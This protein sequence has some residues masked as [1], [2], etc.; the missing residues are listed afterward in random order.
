MK[1][2]SGRYLNTIVSIYDNTI[3]VAEVLI[4][5]LRGNIISIEFNL[6]NQMMKLTGIL[7]MEGHNVQI[8]VMDK[9]TEKYHIQGANIKAFKKSGVHGYVDMVQHTLKLTVIINQYNEQPTSLVFEGTLSGG[10]VPENNLRE[11]KFFYI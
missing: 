9:F 3:S 4:D 11:M 5:N 1:N 7:H 8:Y 6:Y 10:V 2:I